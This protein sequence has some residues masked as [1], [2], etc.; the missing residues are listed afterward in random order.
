M[1]GLGFGPGVGAQQLAW[2][3]CYAGDERA[4]ARMAWEP[5]YAGDERARARA[6]MAWEPCYAGDER[7]V[8]G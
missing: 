8:H 2:E 1:P 3:P 5:C 4:R 6:R 7:F